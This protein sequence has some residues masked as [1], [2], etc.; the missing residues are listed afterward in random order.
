MKISKKIISFILAAVM[1]FSTLTSVW[2]YPQSFNGLPF[3]I[4]VEDAEALMAAR[5]E[6]KEETPAGESSEI[7]GDISTPIA[8]ATFSQ[9]YNLSV[10][11]KV[12]TQVADDNYM[13]VKTA[14]NVNKGKTDD[15]GFKN[16]TGSTSGNYSVKDGEASYASRTAFSFTPKVAG[17]LKVT[18]S[19]IGSGKSAI[20]FYVNDGSPLPEKAG[21]VQATVVATA[22]EGKEEIIAENLT[23]GTTYYVAGVGTNATFKTAT[24]TDG[25]VATPEKVWEKDD[26]LKDITNVQRDEPLKATDPDA[27]PTIW[28]L[29]DSTGC[30]YGTDS[31][32]TIPRNGFGMAFGEDKDRGYV[33]EYGIFDT[34]KVT[35]KNLAIS[36]ISSKNFV[37]NPAYEQLKKGWHKGDYVLI[38]F[39]HNNQKSEDTARFTD[40]SQGADG[41]NLKEQFAYSLYKDYILPAVE[42][43][44][45]PILVTP[46]IRRST[47]SSGPTGDKIHK[48]G[49]GDYRQTIID[50]AKKFN[51]SCID[52][53]YNTYMEHIALGGG[54]DT[55]LDGYAKYHA[56]KTDGS[57]D[58]THVNADGA[59]M[60]AYFMA[61]TM[62]GEAIKYG[63]PKVTPVL[64]A[65]GSA[66][67]D[68]ALS[69]L[70][71]FL[72]SN[73]E[74]P[75]GKE[76]TE[77]GGLDPT[78]FAVKLDYKGAKDPSALQAGDSFSALAEVVNVP[79]NGPVAMVKL[80]L[81]YDP[82]EATPDTTKGISKDG[83]ELVSAADYDAAVKAQKDQTIKGKA[84]KVITLEIPTGT[85]AA[86]I[87][88]EPVVST[89]FEVPFTLAKRGDVAMYVVSA[90]V[91][92]S[93]G[94][95]A[96]GDLDGDNIITSND[97][98]AA[99]KAN[100]STDAEIV[101]KGDV[102]GDGKVDGKDGEEILAK[103]LRASVAF[104][105]AKGEAYE[106]VKYS[107]LGI[108]TDSD[109]S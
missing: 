65:S 88:A 11:G 25:E 47:S 63:E 80:E 18:T 91:Y 72:V 24:F 9:E 39:G 56:V 98:A 49:T 83:K 41:W 52:N 92:S 19:A 85:E 99:Y 8:E 23:V 62:K 69:N 3:I 37:S 22:G 51:L 61:E 104:S 21:E 90:E 15:A 40:S 94:S 74:D 2:A 100:G 96:S 57:V 43:G 71:T 27:K 13:T 53:T 103:T 26:T 101:A 84:C 78:D 28:V 20:I 76:F 17:N 42:A 35:I 45:T 77:E 75:R 59:R 79:Q 73:L 106:G 12:G 46:I 48:C 5:D 6:A 1:V 36:G 33:P 87:A 29:G 70:S 34:S 54:S 32:Y 67:P 102:N 68:K 105:G 44:V 10:T 30:Y 97:A 95:G 16:D 86:A 81:G 7:E 108:N 38:A 4:S 66:D 14:Y 89:S 50:L 82:T 109:I 93:V 64:T 31:G 58:N 55:D 60:I 107:D